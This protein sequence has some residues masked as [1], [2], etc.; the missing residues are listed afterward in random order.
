MS[1]TA[2]S[3]RNRVISYSRGELDEPAAD[4]VLSPL[5]ECPGCQATWGE[6]DRGDT[7][8]ERLRKSVETDAYTAEPEAEKLVALGKALVER[9][10]EDA[11]LP[12]TSALEPS[13]TR[14]EAR[15]PAKEPL[16]AAFGE[17]KVVAKLAQGGM[18]TV[19]RAVHQTLQRPAA[20]KVLQAHRATRPEAIA[21]FYR[22]MAA[23]GQLDHAHIVRAYHAGEQHGM[24]YLVME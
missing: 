17:Y 7:L 23:I 21:R 19:Y 8:V 1:E 14:R 10:S 6:F 3:H 24:P 9:A 16:P 4:Q 15:R 13:P 11:V 12:K 22:E 20:V 5:S 18:G 2:C